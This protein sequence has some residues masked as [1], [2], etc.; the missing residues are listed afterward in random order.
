MSDK[1]WEPE[2]G[3]G[4]PPPCSASLNAR[5]FLGMAGYVAVA[6]AIVAVPWLYSRT[7]HS[8]PV[9]ILLLGTAGLE[10]V[11]G[12]VEGLRRRYSSDSVES[13]VSNPKRRTA[14][15]R[16]Y[17][18]V[19][20]GSKQAGKTIQ[21]FCQS[22]GQM[23]L[24]LVDLI[25]EARL[26]VDEVIDCAGRSLIETI[27]TLSAEQVAGVKTPGKASGEVRW[28]G[29]QPGR[30]R[31]ADRQLRVERPRLR[32]KRGGEVA[33]PAYQALRESKET[34]AEMFEALLKGVSTRNYREVIPRLADSAG[35]S[36]SAVSR[37][38]AEAGARLLE[39]L[40]ER[41]W[42]EVEILVIYID[43]MQFGAHHIISAVGV[44]VAGRKHVLG[45]QLGATENAAAV[46]DLLV[47]LREQGL[48]TSQRY[49][50]VVDGAK[51]LRAAIDEVFGAKQLVQRCRTHKLRNVTERLP[52][53]DKMLR[54]Q[55]RSLL[56]AAW[57]L[58]RAD[59]GMARMN[60]L[61]EMIERDHP[62]AA[63]SL[64]EGLEET[65][66]INRHDVPP[67]L[68]RCLATTNVIESPQS[69]VRKKTSNVCRWRDGEMILRWVAAAFLLT[70]KN[71]RKIMG[72]QDLWTLAAILGRTSIAT[73]SQKEKV[74]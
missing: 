69:G 23:L 47:R 66:T 59:E 70:E 13:G 31:L 54:H 8:L 74:A 55:V 44:D 50:F 72:Y 51:A 52:K 15:K 57:R 2:E 60:K 17:H 4:L 68:H 62:Q 43:G 22:K 30:V 33:V 42:D 24:P 40:R 67:G 49:L 16:K 10:G 61:A 20:V 27:L 14:V 56:R 11:P 46:K 35:V 12:I 19:K 3:L 58:P 32:R 48:N 53:D 71:F 1:D 7:F 45:I 73:A 5:G 39:Q 34:G 9:L 38:A 64:R 37:E 65:F 28:H 26:A 41:R 29:R 21:T 6:V 25:T 18:V 63:A 36:R